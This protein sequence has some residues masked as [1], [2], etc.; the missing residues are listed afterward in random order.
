MA[1]A[2]VLFLVLLIAAAGCFVFF[3][4]TGQVKYKRYGLRILQ[5]TFGTA[6]FFF[7]V[8]AVERFF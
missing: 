7:A 1:I 3:V 8:L 6:F 4:L 2:R 5:W